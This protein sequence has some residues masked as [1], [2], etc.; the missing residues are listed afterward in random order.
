VYIICTYVLLRAIA[1]ATTTPLRLARAS[2]SDGSAKMRRRRETERMQ[3]ADSRRL[4][5]AEL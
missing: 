2:A 5:T 1:S 4:L 3:S